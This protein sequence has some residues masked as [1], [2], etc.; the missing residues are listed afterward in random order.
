MQRPLFGAA[1]CFVEWAAGGPQFTSGSG[2]P[3]G[4][5]GFTSV[6]LQGDATSAAEISWLR[7]FAECE[8]LRLFFSS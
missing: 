7:G 3:Q 5:C 1:F 4:R 2:F 8:G 6:L